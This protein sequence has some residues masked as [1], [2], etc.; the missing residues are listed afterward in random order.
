[1]LSS[2]MCL[3]IF[4]IF[5][6]ILTKLR[7]QDKCESGFDLYVSL[8]KSPIHRGDWGEGGGG[9]C[10]S[11]HFPIPIFCSPP[12]SELHRNV[13]THREE[14]RSRELIQY[15]LAY[16]TRW[17]KHNIVKITSYILVSYYP[18]LF[19][20]LFIFSLKNFILTS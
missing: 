12:T 7:L 11:P 18:C 17:R 19:T 6:H 5:H 4:L 16:R 9:T 1:M 2:C 14:K 20:F 13:H 8:P 15:M 3:Y 10:S